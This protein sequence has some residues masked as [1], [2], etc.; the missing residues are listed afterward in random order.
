MA[1]ATLYPRFVQSVRLAAR[2][3]NQ[4]SFEIAGQG[5]VQLR[6]RSAG[7]ADAMVALLT[8]GTSAEDLA[9]MVGQTGGVEDTVRFYHF[10]EAFKRRRLLGYTWW[11][12][13]RVHAFLEPLVPDF[14]PADAPL[15]TNAQVTLS[16]F[17]HMHRE[18]GG[19]VLESPEA[20]CRMVLETS[21]AIS[22]LGHVATASP[23]DDD[24]CAAFAGLLWHTGLLARI[25]LE[26]PPERATWELHDRLFHGR[27]RAS[28]GAQ[29]L[30]GTYRFEGCFPVPP[31][32]K[33]PMSS[34]RIPLEQPDVD[35]LTVAGE[36]LFSVM[37][38][39]RSVRAMDDTR[40]ITRRQLAEVFYRVAR[41]TERLDVPQQALLRRPFPSGGAIHE[42]E[43]YLA[44][45][46]CTDL[47]Q[48][49]Y[50][51]Q[52]QEH[53]LYRLATAMEHVDALIQDAALAMGQPERPP[54]C[55]IMLASRL[56]RLAWK[57]E[58]IAYRITLMNAGVVLQSL[59]LVATE[60]N[61]AGSAIGTGN[62]DTFAAATG[63]DPFSETS[64]GEFALGMRA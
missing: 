48:G 5:V 62:A 55:L 43:F 8:G 63:L 11:F 1:G 45:R 51:Y 61:L 16:R 27:S 54:Q 25:D 18:G 26:E 40:P 57:Y 7:L 47:E 21:Q 64:V 39:R 53:A 30:G 49:L 36:S 23:M 58:G 19:L 12:S 41:V 24:A 34:E 37:E 60:L 52:G 14:R 35:R 44:V 56:P 4:V 28:R 46:L 31:A 13:G 20:P 6:A 2:A 10:L 32:L 22:W 3:G 38:R 33:P 9:K 59:Y 17:A 50:H 42:L 15:P 29:L